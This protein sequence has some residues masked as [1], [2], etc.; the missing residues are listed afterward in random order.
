[1]V[2]IGLG[3]IL[4]LGWPIIL[5][6]LC[7]S[8][9]SLGIIIEKWTFFKNNNLDIY[10]LKKQL[11]KILDQKKNLNI[12]Q[13]VLKQNY[14][15]AYELFL[16]ASPLQMQTKKEML[17]SML[18][19]IKIIRLNI[20]KSIAILGTVAAI[21]P[22]IG[23]LGTITGIIKTFKIMGNINADQSLIASGIA[24]ALVATALGLL[25]AI[26]ASIFYNIFSEKVRVC[27]EKLDIIT[28][29]LLVFLLKHREKIPDIQVIQSE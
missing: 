4:R 15:L 25:I 3:E 1:M 5:A 8:V 24:E 9:I 6:F 17:E 26:P 13:N 19:R 16:V 18:H 23:L 11:D 22:Y 14:H 12:T 2:D 10:K 29:I 7:C 28:E 21:T 27:V 20:E